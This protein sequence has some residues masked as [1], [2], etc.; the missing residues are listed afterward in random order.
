M[1]EIGGD[2]GLLSFLGT[3]GEWGGLRGL[4]GIELVSLEER[5]VCTPSSWV[6][7]VGF[8]GHRLKPWFQGRKTVSCCE[9][10][11]WIKWGVFMERSSPEGCWL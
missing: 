3:C 1:M 4:A 9:L 7:V 6:I 2:A 8:P 5:N 11:S 10:A